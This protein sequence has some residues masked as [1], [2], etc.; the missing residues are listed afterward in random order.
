MLRVQHPTPGP[1][2]TAACLGLFWA[3]LVAWFALFCA[4]ALT[5]KC[6]LAVSTG[7]VGALLGGFG[8]NFVHQPKFRAHAFV[9]DL[10]A[11]MSSEGWVRE[12]LLQHHMFTNTPLDNHFAGTEPF[13]VVDPTKAR[14]W[15]QRC[16]APVMNPVLLF[17][18]P[19][20]NYTAH[21][22]EL[23]KGREN[24]SVGKLFLPAE[25]AVMIALQG[26][27]WGT[28]LMVVN[29]GL[30][31]TYYFSIAL[32]NHN[33]EHC[34]D[35]GVKNSTQDWGVAQLHSSSDI[36]IGLGFFGSA[37]YLWLNFHTIHHLFP[38]TDMS[39]HPGMQKV[40]LETL[41]EFPAVKYDVREFWPLYKEMI[42]S[43]S[44]PSYLGEEINLYPGNCRGRGSSKCR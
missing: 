21:A 33:T 4:T 16:V 42:T 39:K 17:F 32:L 36:E 13:L 26:P 34:W 1:G 8:H 29:V 15:F 3:L 40:L 11:A 44:T 24:W 22:V 23:A 5:G 2:P 31:G 10:C 28:V 20:V 35:L 18:G 19:F 12:H 7:V 41:K 14:T 25:F 37:K 27:L 9:L 43:F 38:H 30:I 6:A